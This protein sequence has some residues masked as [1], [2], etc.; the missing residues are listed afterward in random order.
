ML[1]SY[2]K[3]PISTYN[4]GYANKNLHKGSYAWKFVQIQD[5]FKETVVRDSIDT[6]FLHL[7]KDESNMAA[8]ANMS[9]QKWRQS[10]IFVFILCYLSAHTISCSLFSIPQLVQTSSRYRYCNDHIIEE[11]ESNL[12]FS[13]NE[14]AVCVLCLMLDSLVS[15]ERDKRNFVHH[16]YNGW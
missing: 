15:Y 5:L 13:W 14:A 4:Y 2:Y 16:N 10:K 6:F 8:Q 11:K 1:K 7:T 12:M 9:R 3:S